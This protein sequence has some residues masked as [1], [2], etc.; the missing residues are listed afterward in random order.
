M[1]TLL[2]LV[3]LL[4]HIGTVYLLFSY[5]PGYGSRYRPFISLVSVLLAGGS[6]ALSFGLLLAQPW[7]HSYTLTLLAVVVYVALL[8][9]HGNVADMIRGKR[10]D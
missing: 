2:F 5:T 8:R 10:N 9:C 3:Q 1:E 4:A 6:L 7:A